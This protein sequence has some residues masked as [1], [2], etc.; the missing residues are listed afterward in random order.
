MGKDHSKQLEHLRGLAR[1]VVDLGDVLEVVGAGLASVD[2]G[3]AELAEQEHVLERPG[4][5]EAT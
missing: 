3:H 4:A 1:G 2:V 5:R